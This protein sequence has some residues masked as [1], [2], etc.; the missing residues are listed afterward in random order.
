MLKLK[1]LGSLS[2][3]STSGSVPAAAQQKRRLGLLALLG[4]AGSRAVSRDRLQAYLWP[5]S[6]SDRSRHALDQLI[7]AVRRSL[8]TDPIVAEGH[9]LKLDPGVIEVDAAGFEAAIDE[10]RWEDA[11]AVY[12]GP[13]LEGYHISDSRDLESWVDSERM[14]L[15]GEYQSALETLAGEAGNRGDRSAAAGWWRTLAAADPLSPRIALEVIQCLADADEHPAA[16]QHA[17]N[18]QQLVREELEIEPDPRIGE[19]ATRLSRL[20]ARESADTRAELSLSAYVPDHPTAPDHASVPD[21]PP[22]ARV[23]SSPRLKV[24][25]WK[26][27]AL[28]IMVMALV[29]TL[30]AVGLAR[31]RPVDPAPPGAGGAVSP[32]AKELYLRGVNAWSNRTKD[33]FDSAVVHFRRAIEIEPAYAEAYGGLANAY[34][35]LGYS[36]YR[37]SS[38]MFPKAKA[39]ALKAIELDSTLAAPWAA[40]GLEL[41]WERKFAE[42]ENAFRKSI[43]VDPLYPTGHQWYGMLHKI[44]GR[45]DKAV[46]E[47]RRAAEL[48]PL[49]L[50][51]QN[52]YGTFLLASGDSAGALR[53]YQ[54]MIGEEPDS[55]WVRRN[56]WLLTNMAGA[57]AANG[58]LDKALDAARR[59]VEINPRHPR[60]LTALAK[61]HI[62]MGRPDIARQVFARV[63]TTNEHYSA[64]RGLFYLELGMRDSAFAH[65]ERVTDWPIPIMISLGGSAKLEGDPRYYALLRKI[66]IPRTRQ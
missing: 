4:I 34:V 45:L 44:L 25:A 16:I 62:R 32:A 29:A 60:S 41:T 40:L 64:E 11:V 9:E 6:P 33:G 66:G 17:R 50:Q 42:A 28:V 14:R 59:S 19:L 2:L 52:T 18:Y 56:P 38:A 10:K 43:A 35:L 51:I 3:R 58:M 53:Q 57:Y 61:V 15:E 48:D 46:S 54:K 23:I 47:T 36:G 39:A 30:A 12:S 13:L 31:A 8:G 27:G 22:A 24:S 63:D 21:Y 49:S 7:Y 37:P 65:L 1:L 20:S 55:G 5:D 26:T